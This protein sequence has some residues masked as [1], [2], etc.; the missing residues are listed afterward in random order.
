MKKLIL[1]YCIL[2]T[3]NCLLPT[4]AFCTHNRAGEITY[5]HISGYTFEITL[6][7]Y[8]YTPSHANQYRDWLPVDWGDNTTSDIQRIEIIELPNDYQRNK[9]VGEHAFPGPGIY[10]IVMQ[11]PNRNEGVDNIPGSVNV[12]FCIKTTMQINPVTG[13]N[14]TPVLLNPPFDK[15]AVGKIFIHNPSAYDSDGD[16]LSYK[17]TTCLGYDGEEIPG[18]TLPPYSNSF[19]INEITGDLIWDTPVETGTYNVAIFIEEWRNGIKIGK[20]LRDMQIEVYNTD[21]DPPE[22]AP[23]LDLCVEAG[24]LIEF[25]VS[26]T[27]VV[28]EVITLTATGGCLLLENSPAQFQDDSAYGF[29][30][31]SFTW[32]TNCSHVRKQPYQV[33]FKA[34]DNNS[35]SLVSIKNINITVVGPAPENLTTEPTNNTIFLNW[36]PSI[37]SEVVGYHI[38]RKAS[39]YGYTHGDCETGVPAYT[40]YSIVGQVDGLNNTNFLDNNNGDGLI[41]GFEYCYMVVAIYPDGAESYAS[42]EV[43]SEL[44]RGIP[45]ITNVSVNTT[46]EIN[47]S[48]YLAWAKPKELDTIPAPG[49]YKYLIYHSNDIW[50]ENLTLI[51]S[52]SDLNDTTY[53]DTFLN[54]YDYPY[55]YK[56]EF[57]N[58][59]PGNRFLIGAP[60][61]A[62]SVYLNIDASDNQLTLNFEKN[63]PWINDYYVIY[64]QA[65]FTD[66]IG[67]TQTLSYIDAGLV[68]GDTICYKVKSVGGYSVEGIIDPIINYS[69]ENCGVPVDTIPPCPPELTVNS[70]CDSLRNELRWTNPNNYCADDV[71]KYNIYYSPSLDGEMELIAINNSPLDTTYIHYPIATMAG[72]YIVTAV[73]SFNNESI[74]ATK[75]CVDECTY[76]ELP[77]VFT[78]DDDNINDLFRP[79]PYRFVEKIDIKIYNRWGTLIFKTDDPDINWDGRNMENHKK[80]SD[81]VYYYICDVYEYRLTGLE[82]RTLIG[83][84][85][86]FTK[87]ESQQY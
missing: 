38:Y 40:G 30:T 59:E 17:L 52:L 79:G 29:V 8:T 31:S 19:T 58:D 62:S 76:Y 71:I 54:T 69:Q 3:A 20:I 23:L 7:T 46:D 27:D 73:D 80:V 48:I 55:S 66:S 35:I 26:A 42:D 81:G 64:K 1:I 10:E 57:Y 87:K 6:M 2:L 15:A 74:N 56:I 50:G 60:H 45:T 25:D 51:D 82:P 83:F 86:I 24:T 33:M 72:C 16:S 78:P 75:V 5:K 85:H 44:V 21:N 84:I 4:A 49:P 65:P 18:Y 77:N 53:I 34:E 13:F 43:C 68:N 67:I 28:T 61:I 14:D 12:V 47:G 39:Y 63:V 32:Q 37:C 9:Y 11:D 70:N 22:I 41:Q 36:A